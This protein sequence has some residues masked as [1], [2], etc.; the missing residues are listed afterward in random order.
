V[1]KLI[2]CGENWTLP[3]A[4]GQKREE[5]FSSRLPKIC[6]NFAADKEITQMATSDSQLG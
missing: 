2:F 5:S 3:F 1:V 6:Q 4:V